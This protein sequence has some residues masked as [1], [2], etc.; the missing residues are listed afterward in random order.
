MSTGGSVKTRDLKQRRNK[1]R[2]VAAIH[3]NRG[4]VCIRAV[5]THPEYDQDKWKE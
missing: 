1:A 3:Y 4:K 2:L 5:L